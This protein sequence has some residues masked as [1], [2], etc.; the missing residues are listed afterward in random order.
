MIHKN[1]SYQVHHQILLPIRLI[2]LH[3]KIIFIFSLHS[4]TGRKSC[5]SKC[6]YFVFASHYFFR[7]DMSVFFFLT[8]NFFFSDI[9]CV[10]KYREVILCQIFL[11]KIQDFKLGTCLGFYFIIWNF[12]NCTNYIQKPCL[13]KSISGNGYFC[14]WFYLSN[15]T[16]IY[17]YIEK[18]FK[19]S[20]NTIQILPITISFDLF[21]FWDA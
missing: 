9:S 1:H 14:C 11:L 10:R 18:K 7:L 4:Y 6:F 20:F 12:I 3:F 19:I 21:I 8:D 2:I 17:I 13:L 15:C 5:I 16:H